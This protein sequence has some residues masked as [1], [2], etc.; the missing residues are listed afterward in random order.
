MNKPVIP[1]KATLPVRCDA[2]P[3]DAAGDGAPEPEVEVPFSV[4]LPPKPAA[5]VGEVLLL[6][7]LAAVLKASN[8]RSPD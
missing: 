8:V 7:A 2:A 3:V 1:A 6:A 4:K 5:D